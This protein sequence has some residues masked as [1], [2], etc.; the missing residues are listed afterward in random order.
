[1]QTSFDAGFSGTSFVKCEEGTKK[2]SLETP[3]NIDGKQ[4]VLGLGPVQTSFWRLLKLVP[5]EGVQK[6]LHVFRRG[7]NKNEEASSI[8]DSGTQSMIDE[9][10]AQPQP[11][12][13]QEGPDGISLNPLPDADRGLVEANSSQ[14]Y[15]KSSAGVGNSK[16]WHRVPYLPSYVPFGQVVIIFFWFQ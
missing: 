4:L 9:A 13:I 1:M 11:L 10:E 2:T 3:K 14:I 12:E 16:R 6:H 15:G 7:R 5:L 8:A